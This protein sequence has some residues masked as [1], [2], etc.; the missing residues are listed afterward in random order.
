MATCLR[1]AA[2]PATA[3]GLQQD[4]LDE[5]IRRRAG[6]G[7]GAGDWQ[8]F[9]RVAAGA[10]EQCGSASLRPFGAGHVGAQRDDFLDESDGHQEIQA[11][12]DRRGLGRAQTRSKL[13]DEVVCLHRLSGAN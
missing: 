1:S 2:A 13:L 3:A 8:A 12:I 10:D 9:N 6:N 4:P 5:K 11:S 7:G